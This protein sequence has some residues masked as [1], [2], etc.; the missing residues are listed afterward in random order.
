MVPRA[1]L[2]FW[3]LFFPHTRIAH[4]HR[5]RRPS[6]RFLLLAQKSQLLYVHRRSPRCCTTCC[7]CCCCCCS[8]IIISTNHLSYCRCW[9]SSVWKNTE[10]LLYDSIYCIA[11]VQYSTVA[12]LTARSCTISRQNL[13]SQTNRSLW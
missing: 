8:C 1:V 6:Q 13:V 2:L 10:K 4:L 7:W 9:S 5:G 12:P 11:V 3:K